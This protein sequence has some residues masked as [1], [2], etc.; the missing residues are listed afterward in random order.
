MVGENLNTQT[1]YNAW[2]SFRIRSFN[3]V[4]DQINSN[5]RT[6]FFDQK[7]IYLDLS[8]FDPKTSPEIE[9]WYISIAKNLRFDSISQT[10]RVTRIVCLSMPVFFFATE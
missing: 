4:V 5:M 2:D 10:L 1:G 7:Q 8:R 6:R 3:V 9:K